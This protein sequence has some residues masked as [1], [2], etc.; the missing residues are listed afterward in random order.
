MNEDKDYLLSWLE[1]SQDG[2][3][4]REKTIHYIPQN[5]EE[6]VIELGK[7]ADLHSATIREIY[8]DSLLVM[9]VSGV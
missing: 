1:L 8:A 7:E 9:P 5:D 2:W 6:L 3:V 4:R